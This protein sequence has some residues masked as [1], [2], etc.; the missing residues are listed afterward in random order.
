[1]AS[2]IR[3]RMVEMPQARHVFRSQ[4]RLS[5]VKYRGE[6]SLDP[7]V[8]EGQLSRIFHVAS[9]WE[10]LILLDEADVYMGK[11]HQGEPRSQSACLSVPPYD[12]ILQRYFCS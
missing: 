9:H 7:A 8:M 12:G 3:G 10:A 4:H 5:F 2:P 6:S 11:T 1:M